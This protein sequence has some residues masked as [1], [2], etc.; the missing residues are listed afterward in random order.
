MSAQIAAMAEKKAPRALQPF[1]PRIHAFKIRQFF[2]EFPDDERPD[3]RAELAE[4]ME[5]DISQV[6]RLETRLKSER[7]RVTISNLQ[8]VAGF[9]SDRLGRPISI[10]DLINA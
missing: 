4:I 1:D 8:I 10:N 9:F 3:A 5:R 7:T 2:D 6:Y